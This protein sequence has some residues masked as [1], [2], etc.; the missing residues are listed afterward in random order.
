MCVSV[1]EEY[2]E[3]I[4]IVADEIEELIEEKEAAVY[5]SNQTNLTYL[6]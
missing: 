1:M 2:A 5:S 6:I 4:A 3:D